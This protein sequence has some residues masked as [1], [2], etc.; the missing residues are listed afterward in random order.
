MPFSYTDRSALVAF[1]E[2]C[3][4][5]GKRVGI[6][7]QDC[8]ALRLLYDAFSASELPE[9]ELSRRI[10]LAFEIKLAFLHT[11]Y[12]LS[13]LAGIENKHFVPEDRRRQY[14]PLEDVDSFALALRRSR[15]AFALVTRIRA[16]WDKLF[17]YVVMT[18][19][20]DAVIR[21]LGAAKSKRR[22]FFSRYADGVGEI[23]AELIKNAKQDLESLESSYRTPELHGYGAI[24]GWVFDTP[25]DWVTPHISEIMAHWNMVSNFTHEVFK[26]FK[27]KRTSLD[28]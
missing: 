6:L 18:T 1:D 14:M 26:K 12:D 27:T 13:E 10:A 15:T 2:S 20:A 4:A 7:T 5:Y 19:E 8:P 28:T 24:R 25:D 3:I 21:Q 22:F 9:R 17:L 16:L 11:H 23:S